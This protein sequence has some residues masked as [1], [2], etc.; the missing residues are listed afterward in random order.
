M[1]R[2]PSANKMRSEQDRYKN[3][4]AENQIL[5]K[6]YN[7]WRNK[8]AATHVIGVQRIA[9]AVWRKG[10]RS[11]EPNYA[12]REIQPA[13]ECIERSRFGVVD[14]AKSVGLHHPVPY[15]PEENDQQNPLQV[16]PKES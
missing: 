12:H 5:A 4:C 3:G 7:R 15:A 8:R 14:S 16:P 10:H 13:R 2:D 1:A 6:V 11:A 9:Q